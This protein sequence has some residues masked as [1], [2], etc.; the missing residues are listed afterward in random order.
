MKMHERTTVTYASVSVLHHVIYFNGI[1]YIKVTR[2]ELEERIYWTK[3]TFIFYTG[4]WYLLNTSM[5]SLF[6][7]HFRPISLILWWLH[8]GNKMKCTAER[9]SFAIDFLKNRMI[10]QRRFE[11]NKIAQMNHAVFLYVQSFELNEWSGHKQKRKS[12]NKREKP[13]CDA[14]LTMTISCDGCNVC[15]VID[16]VDGSFFMHNGNFV[17]AFFWWSIKTIPITWMSMKSNG[18]NRMK[19]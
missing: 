5:Y 11:L 10:T 12:R 9:D 16:K 19:N 4:K 8:W 14:C 3:I 17:A 2:Y 15:Y 1:F 13:N 18:L 7:S 6:F